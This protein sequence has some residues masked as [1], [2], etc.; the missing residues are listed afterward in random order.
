MGGL[1]SAERAEIVL[2]SGRFD[3]VKVGYARLL[4]DGSADLSTTPITRRFYGGCIGR[5]GHYLWDV[6]G[7]RP[8]EQYGPKAP[9]PW[10]HWDGS[11]QPAHTQAEGQAVI[12]YKREV[13]GPIWTAISFW[14]RTVDSRGNSSSN[15][16]FDS[17]LSFDDALADA[18][19]HWPRI[20]E[21]F[22]FEV[23]QGAEAA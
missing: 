17:H 3:H 1:A 19:E 10:E 23:N 14:D 22:T 12:H 15:F 5:V 4:I 6:H 13:G 21:R 11:L 7:R 2:R 16:F 20:F 18:R 8:R 9:I